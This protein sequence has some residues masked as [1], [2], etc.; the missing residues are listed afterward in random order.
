MD[1]EKLRSNEWRQ[2]LVFPAN[3]T[4]EIADCLNLDE[5]TT[6]GSR[7]M[8]VSHSCDINSM[9]Q[10]ETSIEI[11]LITPID[12]QDNGN[13]HGRHPRFYHLETINNAWYEA[14]IDKRFCIDC[15]FCATYAPC[16]DICIS[17]ED[18]RAIVQWIT[19]RYVRSAFPDEFNER[20]KSK[21][22]NL[23]KNFYGGMNQNCFT[24][25]LSTFRRTKICCPA[26]IMKFS[27][28]VW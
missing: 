7:W 20:I 27:Y 24:G 10:S 26:R 13:I 16:T 9:S 22:D 21:K 4:D 5:K 14:R 2:C 1:I 17:K 23:K 15:G 6:S 18:I 19:Y 25:C 28:S 8:V 11:I 12:K 3:A